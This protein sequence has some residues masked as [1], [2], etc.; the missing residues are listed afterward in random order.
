MSNNTRTNDDVLAAVEAVLAEA[1]LPA[2]EDLGMG[3]TMSSPPDIRVTIL[4]WERDSA[5]QRASDAKDATARAER[6]QSLLDEALRIYPSLNDLLQ[7][8]LDE[9]RGDDV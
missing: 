3:A 6:L 2:V 4:M 5:R 8:R 1:G 7:T 9:L